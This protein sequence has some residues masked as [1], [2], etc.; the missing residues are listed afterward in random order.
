MAI[1]IGR[2]EFIALLGGVAS[3]P[4]AARAQQTE[5]IRR[6]GALMYLAAVHARWQCLVRGAC[7]SWGGG[8]HFCRARET[9][10]RCANR[11]IRHHP[12]ANV[13]SCSTG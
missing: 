1:H 6:I 4:L 7:P 13:D 9:A 8:R 5:R 2:R 11:R 10:A 12:P 3:W